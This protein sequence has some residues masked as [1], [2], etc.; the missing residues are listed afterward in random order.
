LKEF[1]TKLLGYNVTRNH[2]HLLFAPRSKE[3][4]A[5]LMQ[6]SQGEFAEWFNSKRDRS[7]AFW[8]DRYHSTMI[9]NDQHLWRCVRYID[10]NMIRAGEVSHPSEWEWCG[11]HE[12][13]GERKRSCLIDLDWW[14]AWSGARDLGEFHGNYAEWVDSAKTQ[15]EACSRE[16]WWT[17]SIAVGDREFVSGFEA[18]YGD[19]A[20]FCIE[21][22]P[23]GVWSIRENPDPYTTQKGPNGVP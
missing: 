15:N 21:K 7:G 5:G 20:E 17:E 1:R 10:L 13:V 8:T 12:L 11:Y 2:V 22:S 9:Q 18:S 19:R 6:R 16:P 4:L 14:L 23:S 3:D